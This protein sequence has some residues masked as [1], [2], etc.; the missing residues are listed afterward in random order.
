MVAEGLIMGIEGTRGPPARKGSFEGGDIGGAEDEGGE[1]CSGGT[2]EEPV[3]VL[4][5]TLEE[6][7]SC[8]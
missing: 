2:R 1:T 6:E 5:C 8:L 3:D 7:V 4:V